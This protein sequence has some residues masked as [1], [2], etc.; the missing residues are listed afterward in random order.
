M[1]LTYFTYDRVLHDVPIKVH[2]VFSRLMPELAQHR[3]YMGSETEETRA[4]LKD[5]IRQAGLDPED[6][7]KFFFYYH[8]R[9]F[10]IGVQVYHNDP[11]LLTKEDMQLLG[12]I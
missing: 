8:Q 5:C 7:A 10:A 12:L 6:W 4:C 11:D 3:C 1:D 2:I 9:E